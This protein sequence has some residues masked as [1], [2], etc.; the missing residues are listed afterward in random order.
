VRDRDEP[1]LLLQLYRRRWLTFGLIVSII[2]VAILAIG[3]MPSRPAW[4]IDKVETLIQEELPPQASRDQVEAWLNQHG[5]T[6]SC[7]TGIADD[8][9]GRKSLAENVELAEGDVGS[10]IRACIPEGER[11]LFYVKEIRVYFLFDHQGRVRK[12]WVTSFNYGL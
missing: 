8:H 7:F 9:D 1:R 3:L 11:G 12:H 5:I 2:V 10:T 4:T 6:Y